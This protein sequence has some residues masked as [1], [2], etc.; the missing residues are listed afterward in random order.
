MSGSYDVL[1][2]GGGPGGYIAAIRAA[3]LGLK[4]ALVE[5]RHLGGICL[6]WGCIPTKALLQGAEFSHALKDKAPML[7][8]DVALNG[9]ELSKL[10]GHSRSVSERLAGGVGY[11]L[12]KN[13]VTVYDGTARLTGKGQ[14][15]VEAKDGAKKPLT[16]AHVILATGARPRVFPGINPDGENVWVSSDAL[17]P[18]AVPETLLVIGSGAIGAEFASLFNDLGTKVHLVEMAPTIMPNEDAEVA[19]FVRKQFQRRGMEIHEGTKVVSVTPGPSGVVCRLSG[20]AGEVELT[21]DKVLSAT[22]VVPNVEDLGLEALGVELDR[23]FIKTDAFCRTNVFGLYAIGDVAGPP[24]LAHKASHEGVLCVEALAGVA[25]V[26]PMNRATIPGCTYTRP[27]VAS[28]GLTEATAKKNGIAVKIGRFNFQ[29]N[30]KAL[31]MG[32]AEGFVKVLFDKETGEL[33]GAHMVGPDVT[34]MIQG[35]GIAQHLE[36]TE[37]SLA[38]VVFAHPTLSEAMHEAVLDALGRALNQ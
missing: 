9:F 29:A 6:N 14:V 36:A 1:V 4:A 34:E 3:Q 8:F 35:Y 7:G 20:P 13:G 18:K 28:F 33:L 15:E 31:A 25:G 12:K 30:G 37:E 19:A 17:V 22:G 10:V 24:C 23:G 27:Q 21:V 32:E 11:L 26:H 5:R 16:A 2:I 38:Q